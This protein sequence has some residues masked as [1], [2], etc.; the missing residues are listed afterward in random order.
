M[1]IDAVKSKLCF[2][3]G[4]APSAMTLQLKDEGGRVL[5]ALGDPARKLGYFSP[6]DGYTLHIIDEDPTSLSGGWVV[7]GGRAGWGWWVVEWGVRWSGGRRVGHAPS[8]A[9]LTCARPPLSPPAANGWLE[10]VSKVEKYVMSDE[11]YAARDNTYRKYKEERL[12]EDPSWT[13]QKELAKRRGV[14]VCVCVG[15]CGV[16][17]V[18]CCVR[19]CGAHTADVNAPRC[20]RRRPRP[21]R[22][23]R[24]SSKLARRKPKLPRRRRSLWVRGVRWRAAAAAS[25][26]TWASARAC[27]WAGGRAWR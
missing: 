9:E 22:L 11:Q 27:R 24:S 6:R 16:G 1:T 21:R 12:R 15:G 2:H 5:A 14:R 3:C 19:V 17:G 26:A 8:A 18:A 7:K 10:D 25:C 20:A 4:T 23:A 13:L